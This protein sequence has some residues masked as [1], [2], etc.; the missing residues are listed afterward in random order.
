MSTDKH[1]LNAEGNP[2]GLPQNIVISSKIALSI[3]IA[4][5]VN[6]GIMYQ[7]FQTLKEETTK[8]S[9]LTA[10]IRENQ[11]KGLADLANLKV[12]TENHETRLGTVERFIIDRAKK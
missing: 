8:N 11:I 3:L 2:V 4:G 12:V 5:L 6:T 10:F 7:Q 9:A 1:I